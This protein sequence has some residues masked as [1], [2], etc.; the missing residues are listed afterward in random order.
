MPYLII[1][2]AQAV[3]RQVSSLDQRFTNTSQTPET[4]KQN[5]PQQTSNM[6]VFN[7]FLQLLQKVSR[8][9]CVHCSLAESRSYKPVKESTF[10]NWCI[11]MDSNLATAAFQL[12][13]E[14]RGNL[15]FIY[16]DANTVFCPSPPLWQHR[17]FSDHMVSSSQTDSSAESVTL[18]RASG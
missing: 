5:K 4:T 7:C 9:C 14:F 2:I 13:L 18:R 17:G 6:T 10:H 8:L 12:T 16:I 15:K 1:H 3:Q 11:F